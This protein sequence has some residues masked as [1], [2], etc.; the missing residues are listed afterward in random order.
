VGGGQ[1]SG[2]EDFSHT[3]QQQHTTTTLAQPAHSGRND[4]SK[5]HTGVASQL[6]INQGKYCNTMA[7][8]F[9]KM[10]QQNANV[11]LTKFST[12]LLG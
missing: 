5:D 9:P 8:D 11:V 7:Q 2:D 12:S 3:Q 1:P 4:R 6:K 10:L